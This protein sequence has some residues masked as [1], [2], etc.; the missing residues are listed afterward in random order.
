MKQLAPPDSHLLDAA[1]GWLGLG[2][3]D[4][5]RAELKMISAGNQ[6]HPDVLEAWW[7]LCVHDKEWHDALKIAELE[8]KSAPGDAGGWLHRA[9]ALRRV[10]G[11]GLPRAWDALLPA[12]AKFPKEPVIAYN[13]ACYACQLKDLDKAREWLERA[14]MA[15]GREE[16]R[17][18]ALAD[19][20]LQQLWPEIAAL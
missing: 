13:L 5:A 8:L 14:V 11:G 17:N 6:N 20:D 15:G 19:E 7:T 16:I 2:C 1:I 3:A 10:K 9:Y 4:D 18:M 12:A